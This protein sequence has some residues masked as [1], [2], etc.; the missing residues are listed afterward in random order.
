M[1]DIQNLIPMI[2]KWEDKSI[3]DVEVLTKERNKGVTLNLYA[4]YCKVKKAPKPTIE[5]LMNISDEEWFDLFKTLF[6]DKWGGDKI[7]NQS[8]A[9]ILVDWLWM[10]GDYGIKIPQRILG[11]ALNGVVDNKTILALNK[12]TSKD[13]FQQIFYERVS[14]INRICISRPA[15]RK[16]KQIWLDRVYQFKFY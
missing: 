9:N 5:Q 2:R 8:I 12:K 10:S 4:L 14:Y 3:T 1:A 15:N 13:L 16:F 6:W 11:V 7:E